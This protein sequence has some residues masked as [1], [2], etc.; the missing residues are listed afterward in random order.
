M[1]KLSKKYLPEFVYGAIDGTVT[2]FAVMAGA[3]GASLSPA[4][5][6]ILGFANLFADGFS[7]AIGNYL[8]TKSNCKV[9]PTSCSEENSKE[10]IKTALATFVSFV[11]IGFIPLFPFVLALGFKGIANNQFLLSAIFTGVAFA[12]TGYIRG[13]VTKENRLLSI[14][15]TLLIGAGAAIIAFFVGFFLQ[16]LI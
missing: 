7:M 2:T 3:L 6:L 10:P 1:N 11:V 9:D 13:Y 5:V 4:I 8:S 16:K 12:V 14:F 15:E